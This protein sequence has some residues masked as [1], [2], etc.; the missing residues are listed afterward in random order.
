ME[1]V[2]LHSWPRIRDPFAYLHHF[3]GTVRDM[4]EHQWLSSQVNGPSSFR[5][6]DTKLLDIQLVV[7]YVGSQLGS[8]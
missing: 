8:S 2:L 6:T 1:S 3:T 5:F 7:D 4:F